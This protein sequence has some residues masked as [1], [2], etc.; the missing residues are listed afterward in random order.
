MRLY[1]Q[2]IYFFKELKKKKDFVYLYFL[3]LF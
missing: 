3:M 1:E 2:V